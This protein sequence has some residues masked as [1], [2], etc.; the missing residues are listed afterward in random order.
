M[1]GGFG[2]SLGRSSA[3]RRERWNEPGLRWSRGRLAASQGHQV[4]VRYRAIVRKRLTTAQVA[5]AKALSLRLTVRL[6][7]GPAPAPPPDDPASPSGPSHDTMLWTQM[8][9]ALLGYAP[10]PLDGRPGRRTTEAVRRFQRDFD[11]ALAPSGRVSEDLLTFLM[12]V[13]D[14][15]EKDPL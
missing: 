6:E 1:L 9:L 15:R 14:A 10:G 5:E 2:V 3:S 8:Y 11:L 13:A 12:G 4:A 7:C